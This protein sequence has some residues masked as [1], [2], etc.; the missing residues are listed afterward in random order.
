MLII[1]NLQPCIRLVSNQTAV[2]K[3]IHDILR[4]NNTKDNINVCSHFL[5]T[6]KLIHSTACVLKFKPDLSKFPTL[7]EDDIEENII[8]GSGPGGQSVNKTS[9]VCHLRHLPTGKFD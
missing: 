9:N 5:K 2:G 3:T 8:K 4:C 7:N 6:G 1:K